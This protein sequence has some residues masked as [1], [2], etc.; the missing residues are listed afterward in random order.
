M[1]YREEW[2]YIRGS[3]VHEVDKVSIDVRVLIR[4]PGRVSSPRCLLL[5]SLIHVFSFIRL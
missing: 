3:L 4:Y 2:S 1:N 5:L